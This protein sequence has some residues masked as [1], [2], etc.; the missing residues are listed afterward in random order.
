MQEPVDALGHDW[1]E[2]LVTSQRTLEHAGERILSCRR[3]GVTETEVLPKLTDADNPFTDNKAGKFYYGPVL[4]AYYHI[5]QITSGLSETEF[6][7][8]NT[9]TRA[10]V[11]TFLWNA[12]GKPEPSITESPFVDTKP[13]KFY[14][15]AMLWALETGVTSGKDDTHFA[16]NETCTRGQVVTF[17]WNA[18]GKPEPTITECPF[19]DVKPG[20]YYYNAMLWALETGVTS[21]KD[22]THFAPNETCTRGQVVTFL[23]NTLEG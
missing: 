18:Q 20:K 10:Q 2:G 8:K 1:E 22:D 5:P 6:G 17:L 14:Y 21:G 11:V 16:P 19:V 12:A 23:Y 13:G 9:C 15:K 4:W 7:P 3:C